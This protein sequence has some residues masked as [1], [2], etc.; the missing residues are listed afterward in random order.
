[1]SLVMSGDLADDDQTLAVVGHDEVLD[2]DTHAVD[3]RAGDD[4]VVEV[5]VLV[6]LYGV[7]R[8]SPPLTFVEP[9]DDGID[10]PLRRAKIKPPEQSVV[11]ENGPCVRQFDR[12]ATAPRRREG[13]PG[14]LSG[15]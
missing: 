2:D 1:M 12:P 3:S 8:R 15:L 10:R 14:R 7:V 5:V 9:S 11:V 6:D 4:G 13:S